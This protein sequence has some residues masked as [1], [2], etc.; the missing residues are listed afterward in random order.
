MDSLEGLKESKSEESF[1][2]GASPE[3]S[4]R[5]L[6]TPHTEKRSG[7]LQWRIVHGII[8][9]DGHRAHP[10]PQVVPC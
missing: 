2:S 6:Y 7:D 1:G 3:G 8:T 9:A 5:S 10:D 4:W